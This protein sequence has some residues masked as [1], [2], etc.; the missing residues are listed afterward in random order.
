MIIVPFVAIV[1]YFTN[2]LTGTS[3]FSFFVS[4][5]NSS[6]QY[7]KTKSNGIL[8]ILDSHG[9]QPR[10]RATATG[11]GDG[12][13]RRATG[14]SHGAGRRATATGPGDGRQATATGP[15]DGRQPRGR[16][17]GDSHGA[18]RRGRATGPGDGAGLFG[19]KKAN[20]AKHC[21]NHYKR[22]DRQNP[23]RLR[24]QHGR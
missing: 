19:K 2:E 14:D 10:G 21:R 6:M 24:K 16:A 8:K 18:G 4:R 20:R 1:P 9:R 22:Y 15:G 7:K 23:V 12:A 3:C 5:N 13:G 17:T 11:P